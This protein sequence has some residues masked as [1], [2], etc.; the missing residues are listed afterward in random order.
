MEEALQHQETAQR[1]GLQTASPRN[2]RPVGNQTGHALSFKLDHS[3]GADQET[4]IRLRSF[5]RWR[6]NE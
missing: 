2:H 3:T 4:I 6:Q 5:S 1:F